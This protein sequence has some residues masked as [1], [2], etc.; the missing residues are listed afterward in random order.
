M[1]IVTPA[2]LAQSIADIFE[3]KRSKLYSKDRSSDL[4]NIRAVYFYVGTYYLKFKNSHL[5]KEIG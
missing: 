3:I 5:A 1:E 4:P 2:Q